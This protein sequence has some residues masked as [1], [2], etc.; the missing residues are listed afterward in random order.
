MISKCK[1]DIEVSYNPDYFAEGEI[2]ETLKKSIED[3]ND[4][5]EKKFGRLTIANPGT[6]NKGVSCNVTQQ[7]DNEVP[8]SIDLV[9]TLV[10][11]SSCFDK[12]DAT[13]MVLPELPEQ[14]LEEH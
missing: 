9:E 3:L 11:L 1:F 14:K 2:R 5:K 12:D 4:S 13:A 8:D 6:H 7:V 10:S